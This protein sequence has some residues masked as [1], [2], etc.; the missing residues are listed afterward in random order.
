MCDYSL[1]HQA[2]REAVAGDRL[3][4]TIFPGSTTLA[5]AG[6]GMPE[7][8]VCLKPGTE[9]AFAAPVT[10]AGL[11]RFLLQAHAHDCRTAR[12]RHVNASNPLVHHDALEF[13]NGHVVLLAHLQ[14]GQTAVVIQLPNG[15]EAPMRAFDFA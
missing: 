5:F 8:A 12:V 7:L 14:P 2:S 6:E 3:V 13:A 15:M 4:T 10:F 11:F 1:E 9:I